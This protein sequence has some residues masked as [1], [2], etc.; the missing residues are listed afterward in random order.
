MRGR[1]KDPAKTEQILQ[2]AGEIF[3]VQGLKGT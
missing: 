1:P 3:L 2:S